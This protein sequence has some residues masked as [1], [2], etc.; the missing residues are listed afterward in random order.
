MKLD[1]VHADMRG[2]EAKACGPS[3]REHCLLH[4]LGVKAEWVKPF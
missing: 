1:V 3:R 2:S 4:R